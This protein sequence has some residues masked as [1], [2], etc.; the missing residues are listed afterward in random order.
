MLFTGLQFI[1]KKVVGNVSQPTFS[2]LF[3]SPSS[4]SCPQLGF[5]I[6]SLACFVLSDELLRASP[7]APL[8]LGRKTP[9][10]AL[11]LLCYN[12]PA[13]RPV[14]C[15][16]RLRSF[17]SWNQWPYHPDPQCVL[18]FLFSLP[19]CCLS[20]YIYPVS[21]ARLRA[22]LHP[23]CRVFNPRRAGTEALSNCIDTLQAAAWSACDGRV[24]CF[25]TLCVL[26]S[27]VERILSLL[28][29]NMYFPHLNP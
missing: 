24:R 16:T 9:W 6:S 12:C 10:T 26:F 4:S 23:A 5:G 19:A 3:S 28:S 7:D 21:P 1:Q 20:S 2:A 11:A 15:V 29:C 14:C 25:P 27:P 22:P 17:F 13:E 18:V 8:A